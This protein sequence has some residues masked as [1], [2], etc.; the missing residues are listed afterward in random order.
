MDLGPNA[1]KATHVH[2]THPA[3]ARALWAVLGVSLL[4][5]LVLAAGVVRADDDDEKSGYL[6]IYMQELTREVSRGLDLDVKKGILISG[7]EDGSPAAEAGLEDG[8]VIIG[9]NGEKVTSPD[10]LRDLVMDTEVGTKVKLTI[11][12]DG[13]K[14]KISVTVGERPGEFNWVFSD[15]DRHRFGKQQ[16]E[17]WEF[18]TDMKERIGH[19]VSMVKPRARLGVH[20]TALN[21]DLASYFKVDEGEGVLVLD[22]VEESV[23]EEAGIKS[24]DVIK[25][26]DGDDV[27]DVSDLRDAVSEL[28]AGDDFEIDLVRKG[29]DVTIEATMYESHNMFFGRKNAPRVKMN[30][31]RIEIKRHFGRDGTLRHELQELRE[32]LNEM[33]KEL[34]ELRED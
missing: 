34:K 15:G 23:A 2:V 18:T 25:T 13:D 27:S 26:V 14:E 6:G 20:A 22:V 9:F 32:E 5:A 7:V 28:D 1:M 29:K 4:L 16:G 3:L 30:A 12:R 21:E 19:Y 8:D 11:V 33:K 24:G 17:H 31:P 10:E